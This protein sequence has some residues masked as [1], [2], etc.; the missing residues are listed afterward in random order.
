MGKSLSDTAVCLTCLFM[1]VVVGHVD[2]HCMHFKK[3]LWVSICCSVRPSMCPT[4]H[5]TKYILFL[6]TVNYLIKIITI[7]TLSLNNI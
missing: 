3:N 7:G 4:I 2:Q 5:S 6:F 1:C